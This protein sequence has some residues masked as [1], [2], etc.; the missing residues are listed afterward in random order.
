MSFSLDPIN[1]TE[2][3]IAKNKTNSISIYIVVVLAVVLVLGLLPVIKVDIS[4]QSR[5]MVR[6]KTENVPITS[7]VSGKITKIYLKNN[8]VLRLN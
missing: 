8:V 3:L 6:S 2:N 5:G 7:L 4:S 1:T